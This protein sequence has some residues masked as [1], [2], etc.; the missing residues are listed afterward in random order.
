MPKSFTVEAKVHK[1]LSF[2]YRVK[3][4]VLN[5]G[6]Y[7]NGVVVFPPN[8]EHDYWT[9]KPPAMRAGRGKYVYIIE[10]DKKLPLWE[11]IFDACVDA[12]KLEQSYEKKD[13]VIT[14]FNENEPINLD[15]L[16]F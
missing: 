14:D 15:S 12:V 4:S 8:E 9:V 2:G 5:L 16:P 1:E 10:F 6:M 11:E 13:V 7:I 3:V